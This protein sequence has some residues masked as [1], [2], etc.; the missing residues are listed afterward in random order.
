MQ[1]G[2]IHPRPRVLLVKSPTNDRVPS[3]SL[4]PLLLLCFFQS[5]PFAVGKSCASTG[6]LSDR[7]LKAPQ[8]LIAD[9]RQITT[10]G[11]CTLGLV[12]CPK[13][14]FSSWRSCRA[15]AFAALGSTAVGP[16][17]HGLWLYGL[18]QVYKQIG[19]PWLV[20]QGL[21]YLLRALICAVSILNYAR[22]HLIPEF[23]FPSLE[24][25]SDGDPD[26]PTYGA[27]HIRS[28]IFW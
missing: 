23:F 27:A 6:R 5:H 17:T 15:A 9:S 21:L 13:F 18:D 2:V 16:V 19:L 12:L 8:E 4:L 22:S 1:P 3:F 14:R 10:A 26:C 20:T 7:S 25:Q 11:C 28:S 24:Y